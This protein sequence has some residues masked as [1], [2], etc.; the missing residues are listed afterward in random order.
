VTSPAE[1]PAPRRPRPPSPEFIGGAF[2]V[3][4]ILVVATSALAAGAP[5]GGPTTPAG[6]D[7]SA[8][9]SFALESAAPTPLV[10]PVLVDYLRK[11]N[12]SLAVN[13]ER[14]E[15]ERARVNLRTD[16][17]Q[18]RIRQVSS[19]VGWATEASA[20]LGPALKKDQPGARMA[21]VYAQIDATATDTLKNSNQNAVAYRRGAGTLIRQIRQLPALQTALEKLAVPPTPAPSTPAP[22]PTRTAAPSPTPTPTPAPTAAPSASARATPSSSLPLPAGDEQIQNGG[23]ETGVGQPWELL[24][25]QGAEAALSADTATPGAGK[26]S[27][28]ID[29]TNGSLAAS[30]IALRQSGLPLE[31]GRQ[32]AVSLA[33]RASADREIRVRLMGAGGGQ[34]SGTIV[35]A[36]TAWTTQ[37]FLFTAGV[38][39]PN[40]V[41]E[42][43]LG[44]D[45]A[46]VW[47]D[48]VSLR[49]LGL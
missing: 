7:G 31:A 33:V 37:P 22:S 44:Q 6:V 1:A 30:G 5:T 27:A 48:S 25:I 13:A 42:I 9:P 26:T 15:A 36:T 40:A 32:Y 34:Y 14:L 47:V 16:D 18:Q 23:F 41:L 4:I 39:D 20:G 10:N 28:R 17:V 49:P 21:E 45:D 43:D 24:L 29:I 38:G 11:L 19:T 3:G 46:T 2:A 35:S 8:E 12:E